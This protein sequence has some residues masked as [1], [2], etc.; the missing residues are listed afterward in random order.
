MDKAQHIENAS[1][2]L[3]AGHVEDARQIIRECY[4]FTSLRNAGRKYSEVDMLRVFYRDG[5]IDR[6]SGQRLIFPGLLR[7]LSKQLPDE[8]PFHP[9]W[10]MDVTHPAYW[11]LM[12]TIDHLVPVSRGGND[13][14]SNWITTSSLRN[15]AK[16]NWTIEELGW[17][18]YPAGSLTEW[19]GLTHLFVQLAEASSLVKGDAYLSRWQWAIRYIQAEDRSA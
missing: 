14:I 18:M 2:A 15:S 7:L 3:I 1:L 9:N 10:K 13:D 11:E 5:F 6:Y 17:P 12:P 4:P 16:A 8:V 19:D